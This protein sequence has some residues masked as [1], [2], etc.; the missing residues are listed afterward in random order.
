MNLANGNVFSIELTANCTLSFSNVPGS[1]VVSVTI[2]IV[3]GGSGSYTVTWPTGTIWPG[4]TAPT[5]TTTVGHVDVI[6]M[7]TMNNGTTWRAFTAGQNF[8]S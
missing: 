3:Q 2:A 5:L 4:G 1:N 8:A 7:L 6:T